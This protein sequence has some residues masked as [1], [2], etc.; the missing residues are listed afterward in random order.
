MKPG[1]I[2][3]TMRFIH[4]WA[5]NDNDEFK[6]RI[7]PEQ[8]IVILAKKRI[9]NRYTYFEIL[10]SNGIFK[11]SSWEDDAYFEQHIEEIS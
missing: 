10:T 1:A 7:E 3:K 11:T 5:N 4:C 2:Y 9:K 6:G 8:F